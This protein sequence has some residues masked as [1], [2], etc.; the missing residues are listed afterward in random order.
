M[1]TWINRYVIEGTDG[2]E[3]LVGFLISLGLF[4]FLYAIA[5]FVDKRKKR[6]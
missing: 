3:V 1:I 2:R 6:G 5:H 4:V